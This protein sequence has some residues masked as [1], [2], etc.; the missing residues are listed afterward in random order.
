MLT[1]VCQSNQACSTSLNRYSWGTKYSQVPGLN[2]TLICS[3]SPTVYGTGQMTCS[4][5]DPTINMLFPGPAYVTITRSL[6][7]TKHPGGKR[8]LTKGGLNG[9]EGVAYAQIWINNVEQ[10]SCM[11][12]NCT[13]TVAK[14][15]IDGAAGNSTTWDCADLE[16]RCNGESDLCRSP[17]V[18]GIINK[19]HGPLSVDCGGDDNC[20][21]KQQLVT[22]FFGEKGLTLS[23]CTFGECVEQSTIDNA[24][25]DT[26]VPGPSAGVIA[27]LLAVACVILAVIIA[28]VNG[29]YSRERARRRPTHG[30]FMKRPGVGLS[31][32]GVGYEVPPEQR[33]FIRAFK[34]WLKGGRGAAYLKL[35]RD[36]NVGPHGGKVVLRDSCGDIPAGGFCCLLGPSGAGKSTLVDILSGQNKA[37]HVEGS[38]AYTGGGRIK[39]AYVDQRDVLSATATVAETLQFAADLR[40]P[41]NIPAH[42]K[43]ERVRT[44]LQQLGLEHVADTR[45]GSGETR[46][47][48]GGEMRRVSIGVELISAPDV[49]ILDE[50]TSGLDS[51]SAARIVTLLK[52]I[53]EDE[54]C[55][56]TVI[57][58]IHQPSS[59]LYNAFSQV[60]L[61]SRGKQLYFG[62]GGDAPADY[63]AR[64]GLP[65]PAHYNVADHLLEIA[66]ASPPLQTGRDAV[67]PLNYK[68]KEA[69]LLEESESE[70]SSAGSSELD[71][72]CAG[73]TSVDLSQRQSVPK[74]AWWPD[75]RCET[76]FLTQ[77]DVLS[78]R[79]W[80]NLMRDKTLFVSHVIAGIVLG[81]FA[82][83]V[84]SRI[85]L[86]ISGFR[87][88]I[89]CLFF[90]C[91]L[92][93][94]SS[95][96]ALNNLVEA[97]PL[98]LRERGG[99]YSPSAW[100]LCRVLF[101]IVPLRIIPISLL[102]CTTYALVGLTPTIVNFSQF[103]LAVMQF[104]VSMALFNFI[105]AAAC[106]NPALAV[107]AS[108]LWNMFNFV[109]AGFFV[110]L[111]NVPAWVRWPTYITPLGFALEAISV[112]EVGAGLPIKD[113][114]D[115]IAIEINAAYIMKRLFGYELGKY[116]GDV[117]ALCWF[118]IG[119]L[120]LLV[121]LVV[122]HMREH[123]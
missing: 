65:C 62:P 6:N 111:E 110:K 22:N 5:S 3:A 76:T 13:Q 15:K 119:Y 17:G 115:G 89:G 25:F 74:S 73:E 12:Q 63:F 47:V 37:G 68:S 45:I 56:T 35:E 77:M 66:T 84:F 64:F 108:N 105:L 75:G 8:V 95:L 39:V 109:Y 51:V 58:S 42:V 103:Y 117:L 79:E 72:L 102:A 16:C 29:I 24:S 90:I 11:A 44:V 50:P 1:S 99:F 118:L 7:S 23:D 86:S 116:Y 28:T 101:D 121:G 21:F 10:F 67:V 83:G 80:A 31:W 20:Q 78:K 2:N 48:S 69:R 53:T 96:S 36:V 93:S 113:D 46:G 18:L 52:A 30:D 98:F 40:L 19:L 81:L 87:N 55:P 120:V 82:S 112:N 27:G 49:L 14:S 104:A 26:N 92:V 34:E 88:R 106:S 59:A 41:E 38:V 43:A 9:G 122:Y 54:T 114:L 97:R 4:L 91:S 94:F 100:L 70:L 32:S 71:L 61:L 57:A 60:L 33:G 123:R 85:D 107:L